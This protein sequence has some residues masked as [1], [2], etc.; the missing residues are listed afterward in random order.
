MFDGDDDGQDTDDDEQYVPCYMLS[1]PKGSVVAGAACTLTDVLGGEEESLPIELEVLCFFWGA[2]RRLLF[3]WRLVHHARHF[4]VA[5][6][7]A[8]PHGR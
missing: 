5:F 6:A 7:L 3:L 2:L 4:N 1:Q 8:E